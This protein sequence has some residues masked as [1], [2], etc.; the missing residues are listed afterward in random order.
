[1][2]NSKT[3]ISKK[4]QHH[5]F[6][7]L[8]NQHD[9]ILILGSFPSVK[10]R[11]NAFYYMHPQNRFWQVLTR[12]FEDDFVNVDIEAKIRLLKKHHIALYD[13]IERCHIDG[14]KDSSIDVKKATDIK[15]L[16]QGTKINH[17]YFNGQT[18]GR[19]YAEFNPDLDIPATA[20]PSTSSANARYS[21]NQLVE[22]WRMICI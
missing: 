8:I 9:N 12:L 20:L 13:V 15:A 16:I 6:G 18:A 21:L 17:I 2:M 10:S 3:N 4:V 1:M 14:S 7:P 5:G 22:K 19:I 11:E